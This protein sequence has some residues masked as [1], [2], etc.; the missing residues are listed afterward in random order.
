M[1]GYT[2]QDYTQIFHYYST[3][4]WS[5]MAEWWQGRPSQHEELRKGDEKEH[6]ANTVCS[7]RILGSDPH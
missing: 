2:K 5:T 3:C 1:G 6:K 7:E 4:G